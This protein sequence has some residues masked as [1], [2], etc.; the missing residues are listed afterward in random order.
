MGQIYRRT[1]AVLAGPILVNTPQIQ[2]PSECCLR[3]NTLQDALGFSV[4]LSDNH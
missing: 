2:G 1:G 4:A 3:Q